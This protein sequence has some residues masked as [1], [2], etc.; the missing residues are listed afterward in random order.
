MS[1]LGDNDLA[2]IVPDGHSPWA[3]RRAF[4]QV[5]LRVENLRNLLLG[6]IVMNDSGVRVRNDDGTFVRTPAELG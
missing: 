6:F 4:E 2:P 1:S 3:I 5:N